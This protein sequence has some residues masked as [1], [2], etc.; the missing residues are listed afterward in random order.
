MSQNDRLL[1]DVTIRHK[2]SPP[3]EAKDFQL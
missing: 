1:A 2:K 3:P